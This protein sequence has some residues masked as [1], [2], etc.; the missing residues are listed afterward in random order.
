MSCPLWVKADTLVCPVTPHSGMLSC[1]F[2][3]FSTRLLRSMSE[4]SRRLGQDQP[5]TCVREAP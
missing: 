1:F 3:V 2:Q 5:A 4:A